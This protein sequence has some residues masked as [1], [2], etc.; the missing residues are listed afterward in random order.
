MPRRKRPVAE[1]EDLS[2][3]SPTTNKNPPPTPDIQINT[4]NIDEIFAQNKSNKKQKL[5]DKIDQIDNKEELNKRN[6]RNK[7][8][9][10]ST[11]NNNNNNNNNN[12]KLITAPPSKL[13]DILNGTRKSGTKFM[14]GLRVYTSDELGLRQAAGKE[15]DLCPFDCDCCF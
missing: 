12:N 13:D 7:E 8:H 1:K 6:K 10:S 3:R 11:S 5:D 9:K 4:F 15:T 14:D 2:S